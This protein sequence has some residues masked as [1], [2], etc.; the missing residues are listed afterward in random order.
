MHYK[1]GGV[2][3]RSE[4][5][6]LSSGN[7]HQLVLKQILDWPRDASVLD[8]GC[9]KLRYSIPL[10]RV[11]HS[12]T[13]I[14]SAVQL[15]R[16]QKIDGQFTTLRQFACSPNSNIRVFSLNETQWQKSRYDRILCANVLS[17]I[18]SQRHR[19][20]LM[21]KIRKVLRR[22][23]VALIVNQHRNSYFKTYA[24]RKTAR[25]HLDGWLLSTKAGT[26]F[27]GLIDK[28][29]LLRLCKRSRLSVSRIGVWGES[30]FAIVTR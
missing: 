14:D 4:Y 25:R 18:P 27:Y 20:E 2:R 15:M 30:T 13:A 1:I 23:G 10:A 5:A 28:S 8:Y 29:V 16:T 24:S 7:P 6:A 3:I 21:S 19:N 9:G 22:D 17:A 12:V 26:R 11:V